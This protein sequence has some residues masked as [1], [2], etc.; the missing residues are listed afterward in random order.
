MMDLVLGIGGNQGNRVDNLEKIRNRIEKQ[1]GRIL[2]KSPL[3]ESEPWGFES[4]S[5]FLNQVVLV[6]CELEP[7]KILKIIH[8]IESEFGRIRTGKYEDRLV[9]IDI[10][11]YGELIL[12]DAELQIPHPHLHKRLFIM[13]PIV[14]IIPDFIHPVFH[15]SLREI[16]STCSDKS[17]CKWY[18]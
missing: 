11:L 14:E 18:S 1:F 15:K 10:L 5:W 7:L 16:L 6:K 12:N 13:K 8:R 9:D 3:V 17:V 4:D 2:K